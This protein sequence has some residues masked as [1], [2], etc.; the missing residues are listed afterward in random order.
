MK[1][2]FVI[3]P[4]ILQPAVHLPSCAS[5]LESPSLCCLPSTYFPLT[6]TNCHCCNL[7]IMILLCLVDLNGYTL[8]L[9][10]VIDNYPNASRLHLCI[11]VPWGH[12]PDP[13]SMSMLCTLVLLHISWGTP[14]VFIALATFK[15]KNT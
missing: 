12:A 1:F 3:K 6:Y 4:C 13:P 15:A 2:C 9:S 8:N 11:I 7:F 10:S 5:A 14:L